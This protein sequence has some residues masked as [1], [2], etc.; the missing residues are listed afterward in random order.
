M[1]W[2]ETLG[3]G[4]GGTRVDVM[5]TSVCSLLAAS[6]LLPSPSLCNQPAA[7][8]CPASGSCLDQSWRH[9]AVN[10]REAGLMAAASCGF[11][12]QACS[13]PD[14][15]NSPEGEFLGFCPRELPSL[16]EL[17]GMGWGESPS[18]AQGASN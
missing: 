15:I 2:K 10:Q 9:L 5:T 13:G 12:G 6:P 14:R 16:G 7:C 3:G 17:W 11:L 1:S 8:A 18:D 4:T